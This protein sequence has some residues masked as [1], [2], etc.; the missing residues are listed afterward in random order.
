MDV[1]Q[2]ADVLLINGSELKWNVV[3]AEVAEIQCV[4]YPATSL[5]N[6]IMILSIEIVADLLGTEVA[7]ERCV[8]LHFC[9]TV[10]DVNYERFVELL[11]SL[12][13]FKKEI[14]HDDMSCHLHEATSHEVVILGVF[15]VTCVTIKIGRAHV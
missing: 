15:H 2:L 9:L 12:G 7:D 1:C 4:G 11:V 14:A 6:Q 13:I 8:F 10:L 3:C 5:F